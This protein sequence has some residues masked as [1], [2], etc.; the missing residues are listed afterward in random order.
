MPAG[1]RCGGTDFVCG[2]AGLVPTQ[3]AAPFHTKCSVQFQLG[4][5]IGHGYAPQPYIFVFRR[6]ESRQELFAH[7]QPQIGIYPPVQTLAAQTACRRLYARHGYHTVGTRILSGHR[8]EHMQK[9]LHD[10]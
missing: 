7:R 8:Y 6:P 1:L 4:R 3:A 9:T 10:R 2:Q 5:G